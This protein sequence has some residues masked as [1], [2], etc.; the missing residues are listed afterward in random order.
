MKYSY[1]GVDGVVLAG[2]PGDGGLEHGQGVGGVAGGGVQVLPI[3]EW[4][5]LFKNNEIFSNKN[6]IFL[7]GL[8]VGVQG[9]LLLLSA[10][11]VGAVGVAAVASEGVA[12]HSQGEGWNILNI[13]KYFI[14]GISKGWFSCTERILCH[15]DPVKGKKRP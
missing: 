6:E 12:T 13:L 14:Y 4:N 2:H 15:K 8:G 1:L 10:L 11:A 9:G 3:A 5:I 7:P